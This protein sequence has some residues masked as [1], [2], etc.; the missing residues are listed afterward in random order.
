MS[1]NTLPIPSEPI[2]PLADK[3][4][5]DIGGLATLTSL[6]QR[7]LRRMDACRDIPGRVAVGRRVLFQTEVIRQWVR[8]GMP[9]RQGWATFQKGAKR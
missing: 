7:T 8:S 1:N 6:S 5:I 9:D 4:L 3:L 2:I